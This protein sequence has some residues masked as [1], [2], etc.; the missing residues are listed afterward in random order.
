[1]NVLTYMKYSYEFKENQFGNLAIILPE[2]MSIFADFIQDISTVEEADEYLGY[3]QNVTDG[4]Y[5]N[6]EITLNATSVIIKK[7]MKQ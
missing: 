5:E 2:E 4:E 7:K 3:I 1:M 6:F